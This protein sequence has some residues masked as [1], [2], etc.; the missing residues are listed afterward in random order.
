MSRPGTSLTV[1]TSD[2]TIE[3]ISSK[4]L[5]YCVNIR[6]TFANENS[7]NFID[8]KLDRPTYCQYYWQH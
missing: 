5:A 7:R 6:R 1:M 3:F 2:S 4:L 8:Y